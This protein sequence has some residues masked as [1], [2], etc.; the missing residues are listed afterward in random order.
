MFW[1]FYELNWA[2]IIRILNPQPLDFPRRWVLRYEIVITDN[3]SVI[4]N[5]E[6]KAIS[7]NYLAQKCENWGLRELASPV[8]RKLRI[9]LLQFILKEI[10]GEDRLVL[11]TLLFILKVSEKIAVGAWI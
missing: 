1:P 9:F 11:P 2:V 8:R 7:C 10:D 6:D 5:F 3:K 4:L